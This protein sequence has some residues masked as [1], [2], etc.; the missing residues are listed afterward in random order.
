LG[1]VQ[2]W[3]YIGLYCGNDSEAVRPLGERVVTKMV[4]VNMTHHQTD[5]SS[6]LTAISQATGCLLYQGVCATGITREKVQSE[7]K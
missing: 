7:S 4:N 6:S 3:W 5:I 1:T 2:Q